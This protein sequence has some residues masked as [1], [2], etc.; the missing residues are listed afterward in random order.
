VSLRGQFLLVVLLGV[1]VPLGMV[2]LWLNSSARRSGEELV[3]SRLESSLEEL[4]ERIGLGWPARLS[5]LLDLTDAGAVQDAARGD[6]PLAELSHETAWLEGGGL[7]KLERVR[8][9]WL[10]TNVVESAAILGLGGAVLGRLPDDLGDGEQRLEGPT[11]GLLP[12]SLPIRERRSG[13]ILGTLEAQLRIE[14]LLPPGAVALGVGGASLALFDPRDGTPLSPLTFDPKVYNRRDFSWRGERWLTA[15]SEIGDPP[16]RFVIASPVE[17]VTRP[18][19]EA[20]RRGTL[21]LLVAVAG[22]FVLATLFTRRLTRSLEDLAVA[23]STVAEGHLDGRAP[24]RGPPEVRAT[25]GAFNAMT[26]SLSRTLG[27]LAQQEAV[28]AVGEFAASLAHEVRNPLTSIRV[29]LQRSQRKMEKD[30]PEAQALVDLALRELERLDASVDDVLRIARSGRVAMKPVEL[31]LPIEAAVRASMPRFDERGALLQADVGSEP[32]WVTGDESALEQLVLNLLL[33]AAE[34]LP[35]GG[36]ADLRVDLNTDLESVAVTV[37]D[38]GP[39]IPDGALSQIFE[40]FFTTKGEGTGLGLS[41]ARRI[42]HAHGSELE[43]E[44]TSGRGVSF[45]F[46]L[47]IEPESAEAGVTRITEP[48][49]KN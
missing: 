34:A 12:Y 31:R 30:Q 20:A 32:V 49:K 38:D 11:L 27:R 24:E 21:A 2:G 10:A 3:R 23:A 22:V 13:A 36:R 29:D 1:V 44:N 4:A 14:T 35:E 26:R 28:A 25:A 19:A 45:R 47:T 46:Y 6:T 5:L 43:V 18:F 16:L 39:G 17:P 42:A 8:A 37:T 7:A 15:S 40:P 48:R 33:N 9:L 41:V